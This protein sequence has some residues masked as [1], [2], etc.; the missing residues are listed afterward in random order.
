M[1]KY[2]LNPIFKDLSNEEIF[3]EL[4]SFIKIGKSYQTLYGKKN[5][6]IVKIKG[7]ITIV[8]KEASKKSSDS[9]KPRIT[10]FK[11]M[12]VIALFRNGKE[13]NTNSVEY[14]RRLR[15]KPTNKTPL[16]SILLASEIIIDSKKVSK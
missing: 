1:S 8:R 14:K 11:L 7:E 15:R 12:N 3:N 9:E 6:K 5:H 2:K 4:L 10:F 16:L 13:Y